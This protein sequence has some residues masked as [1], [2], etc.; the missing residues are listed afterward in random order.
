MISLMT[1]DNLPIKLFKTLYFL[2]TKVKELGVP[3]YIKLPFHLFI[4]KQKMINNMIALSML[5]D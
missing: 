2:H 4:E 1:L 3:W 5:I